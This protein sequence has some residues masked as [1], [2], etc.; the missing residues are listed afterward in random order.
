MDAD[1]LFE[2]DPRTFVAARDLLAKELRAAGKRDEAAGVRALRRPSVSA[3]ALNQVARR[4]A[5]TVEELISSIERARVAQDEV[6]AGAERQTLRDAM[7]DR[8][9][10]LVAVI[11]HARAVMEE[12]GR[13]SDTATRNIES[14]LQGSL[15]PTFIDAFRRGVLT[16]LDAGV[17]D[18]D[19]L[20]ALL[21]ASVPASTAPRTAA[22][23]AARRKKH[24]A[25]IARLR[26][27]VQTAATTVADAA[28][29]LADRERE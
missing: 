19:S 14:A 15:P 13:P 22:V 20:S 24:E 29:T 4:D 6:L 23:D 9:Q 18:E 12:S 16:D 2:E 28:S 10:A 1:A 25:E 11:D 17:A 5:R 26:A 3:W 7:A 27:A 21:S 8:R